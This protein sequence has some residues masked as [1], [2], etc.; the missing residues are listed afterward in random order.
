MVQAVAGSSP[1]SHP[2]ECIYFLEEFIE[3]ES[4]DSVGQMQLCEALKLGEQLIDAA[5]YLYDKHRLVSPRYQAS[6][7]HAEAGWQLCLT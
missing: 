5:E 7:H 1:V 3:G 4:L 6:K 2:L